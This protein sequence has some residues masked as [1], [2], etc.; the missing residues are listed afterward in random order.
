M[1]RSITIASIF[2]ASLPAGASAELSEPALR[3][4]YVHAVRCFA[5]APLARER[6]MGRDN[7]I[8]AYDMAQALGAR[9]GYSMQQT[10]NDVRERTTTELAAMLRDAA[11]LD[12]TLNDCQRLGLL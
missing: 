12:Q 11:Y 4:A 5:V 6:G 7:G 10:A 3:N 8:R 2:V 9:L 1:R